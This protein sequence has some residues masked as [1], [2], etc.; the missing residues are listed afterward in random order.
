[1][2]LMVFLLFVVFVFVFELVRSF[3]LFIMPFKVRM[4]VR[5][6]NR[7]FAF[8][9]MLV[10]AALE[11][12]LVGVFLGHFGVHVVLSVTTVRF[13]MVVAGGRCHVNGAHLYLGVC[14]I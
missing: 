4:N 10:I 14:Y 7:F 9:C 8:N 6:V 3:S 13:S 1:M 12:H 2:S 11:A 5:F